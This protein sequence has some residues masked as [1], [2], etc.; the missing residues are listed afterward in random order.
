MMMWGTIFLANANG[1]RARADVR[2]SEVVAFI[3]SIQEK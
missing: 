2:I 3:Q 1:D